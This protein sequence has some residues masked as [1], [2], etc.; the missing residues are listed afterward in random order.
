MFARFAVLAIW[1]EI[2]L[3]S[4]RIGVGRRAP[5]QLRLPRKQCI[6]QILLGGSRF[7]FSRF[8][9]S[10]RMSLLLLLWLDS[11]TGLSV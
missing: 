11:H 6:F 7:E 2:L 9:N 8:V 5:A 10:L 4:V 3:N 1:T